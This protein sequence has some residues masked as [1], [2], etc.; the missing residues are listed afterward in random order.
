VKDFLVDVNLFN[1][2]LPKKEYTDLEPF[3]KKYEKLLNPKAGLEYAMKWKKVL[4]NIQVHYRELEQK[5]QDLLE[6]TLKVYKLLELAPPDSYFKDT[7]EVYYFKP[8]KDPSPSSVLF[9]ASITY[10]ESPSLSF[11]V[12]IPEHL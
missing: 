8:K 1:D 9:G 11:R 2:K 4:E 7:N 10:P 6:D 5:I 12:L 3:L